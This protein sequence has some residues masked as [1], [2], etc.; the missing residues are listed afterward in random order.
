MTDVEVIKRLE[1]INDL[2]ADNAIIKI[3][4]L[5]RK[6]KECEAVPLIESNL[7]HEKLSGP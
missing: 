5:R 4:S 6:N 1:K 2:E 7:I 3:T